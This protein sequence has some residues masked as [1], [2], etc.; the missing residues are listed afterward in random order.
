MYLK[1]LQMENFKSFGR[2]L[3]IPL[4]NGFTAIT[5]PNGCGKSN[6]CD[7]IL[8]VLGPKSSKVMRA[9]RLTDLIYNGGPSGRPAKHCKVSLTL[10]NSDHTIPEND[11]DVRLT[12]TVK[13]SPSNPENYYSYFYIN[14]SPVS[15]AEFDDLLALAR[16]EGRH[17]IVQQGDVNEIITIGNMGRRRILD[18]VAGIARFDQEIEEADN[19]RIATE[20]NIDRIEIVKNEVTRQMRRLRRERDDALRYEDCK[21]GLVGLQTKLALKKRE[22]VLA[23]IRDVRDQRAHYETERDE[24]RKKLKVA[25]KD[26][27]AIKKELEETEEKISK[28]GGEEA[29]ELKERVDALKISRVKIEERI[30]HGRDNER[31]LTSELDQLGQDR[32]RVKKELMAAKAAVKDLTKNIAERK[33]TLGKKETRVKDLQER[34]ASTDSQTM[35][36]QRELVLLRN[37]HQELQTNAHEQSLQQGKI[38]SDLE[39]LERAISDLEQEQ[40]GQEFEL[41]DAKWGHSEHKKKLKKLEEELNPLSARLGEKRGEE[42]A[43]EARLQAL[44]KR[45]ARLRDQH[46]QLSA[47]YEAAKHVQAGYNNAVR[48]VLGARD[49]GKLKGIHG[50]VSELGTVKKQYETALGVAA[51]QR[52]QSIVVD[53]DGDAAAAI[54]YLKRHKG[55]RATFLPLNRMMSRKPGARALLALKDRGAVGLAKSLVKYDSRY[56]AAFNYVFGDTVVVSDLS[57]ARR[58]MGGVRLVTLDGELIE[59]AGAMI[60]GSATKRMGFLS[61]DTLR[62]VG[63]DLQDTITQ[64]DEARSKF[65]ETKREIEEIEGRQRDLQ[66]EIDGLVPKM[67]ELERHT[68][69]CKG[70]LEEIKEILDKK[71]SEGRKQRSALEECGN[72][73]DGINQEIAAL[74]QTLQQKGKLLLASTQK[75]IADEVRS[76][77]TDVAELREELRDLRSQKETQETKLGILKERET[78]LDKRGVEIERAIEEL[79]EIFTAAQQ[80]LAQ[81]EEE[82]ATLV[83]V[84]TAQSEQ[85]GELGRRRDDT[86]VRSIELGKTIE[87][88][89][90]K[91]ET[92]TDMMSD[93]DNKLPPLQGRL[94][95]VEL[96]LESYP[97][98]VADDTSIEDL[99]VGI[100]RMEEKIRAMEPVNMMAITEY[101]HA[102]GRRE[103]LKGELTQL[104]GQKE[105]LIDLVSEIKKR[106][107]DRFYEVYNEINGHFREVYTALS[108]GGAAEMV[109]ENEEDPFAEGLIIRAH[110]PG[111]RTQ[112]LEALS[113]GEKSL[114]ALAFIFALQKFDP[115]PFY[116][117]DEIDMYLDGVNA[118]LAAKMIRGNSQ[119]AQFLVT[120][121]RRATLKEASHLYGVTM[122]TSGISKVVGQVN[123]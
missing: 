86:L 21:K 3:R 49:E 23:E 35:T 5:G 1:E 58:L 66:L 69:E 122:Q 71:R 78:E 28:A 83:A 100:K 18:D 31:Q 39:L 51:G 76:K 90:T 119:E 20:A 77:T 121:L 57:T 44:E 88:Y 106:K 45:V 15:M 29:R 33:K 74:D 26:E 111:K 103:R 108:G 12:R 25:K 75:K 107:K 42:K 43:L 9:S 87:G 11:G 82:L 56:E 4:L 97:E 37:R 50:P 47:E 101:D 27:T 62:K 48:A 68:K 54:G 94:R 60:G 41:K 30:K 46:S 104:V 61:D 14:G 67:A 55:G 102:A 110:P 113:G 70:R 79:K 17:N 117:L 53:T 32:K 16:L 8:F 22:G 40:S 109:P 123:I 73:L 10:D 65:T 92:Y 89:A 112:R 36:L 80:Q 93:L 72:R 120:S 63:G 2:R 7:A 81:C 38:Q 96:E 118:E 99:K 52:M 114:V 115:S 91:V 19:E 59:P 116:V 34:A 13:L 85:L 84:Q 105:K 98:V 24:L 6:I 64:R 95:E